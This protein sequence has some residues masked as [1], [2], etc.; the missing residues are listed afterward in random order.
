LA[1]ALLDRLVMNAAAR[2]IGR[3]AR[4][5]TSGHGE[6]RHPG[7]EGGRLRRKGRAPLSSLYAAQRHP[8]SDHRRRP[9]PPPPPGA[10]GDHLMPRR[11]A[12]SRRPQSDHRSLTTPRAQTRDEPAPGYGSRATSGLGG[13]LEPMCWQAK[14]DLLNRR[15]GAHQAESINVRALRPPRQG[16]S[17]ARSAS[18]SGSPAS[19]LRECP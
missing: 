14:G 8:A 4:P 11:Q 16:R 17:L 9:A 5:A 19:A 3:P 1:A 13:A 2:P 6:I 10:Q 12:D 7:K 18:L 15:D